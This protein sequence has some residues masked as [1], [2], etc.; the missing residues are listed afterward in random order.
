[1]TRDDD[2]MGGEV[3]TA[4]P[5]VVRRVAKEEVV[6][7]VWRQLMRS[8]SRS[9]GIAGTTEHTDVVIGGGCA[10]QGDVWGGVAH[11]LRWEAVEEVGCGV[12][13][14][15]LVAGRERHLEQKVA[16]HVSGGANHA[17]GPV[18]LGRGVGA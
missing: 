1:V 12:Q 13:G 2:A 16:D 7:G 6:S 5:L 9:V 17:F 3:K 15:F 14:L 18:V 11:H 4:I 10:I 8:N